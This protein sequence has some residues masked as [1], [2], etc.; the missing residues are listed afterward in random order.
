MR[1]L[2]SFAAAALLA[3]AAAAQPVTLRDSVE[4][5]GAGITLGDLFVEAGDAAGR[6]VAPAPAPG[7]TAK[8]SATFV[9]AA[10]KSAGLQ[11]TPPADV[12]EISITRAGAQGAKG[13]ATV[14]RGE[15]LTVTYS[16]PGLRL[17]ARARATKD[18]AIGETIRVV[19][20]QSNREIDAVVT[21][22]GAASAKAP[23]T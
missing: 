12:T 18:A 17:A 23:R 7:K 4:A 5:K 3:G 21:G 10:A 8:L 20:V 19:N 9:V 16:G 2:A 22:P 14:K 13:P 1:V 6:A 15:T 11:W